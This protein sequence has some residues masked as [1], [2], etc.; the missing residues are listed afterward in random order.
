MKIKNILVITGY[1]LKYTDIVRADNC[2]LYDSAGN[3]FL[4]LESGVWCT[5]VGHCYPG[6]HNVLADSDKGDKMG[7]KN[8]A[9]NTNK[10]KFKK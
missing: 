2:N 3:Q 1:T 9:P 4:D 6:I 10:F 8:K 5:S 7:I